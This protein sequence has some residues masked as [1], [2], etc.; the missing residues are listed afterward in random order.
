[1]TDIAHGDLK[2]EN[3]L[4]KGFVNPIAQL[5][6]FDGSSFG[7]TD[8][9]HVWISGTKG[10]TDPELTR[11]NRTV[12]LREA[13]K[14]DLYS[15]GKL[16]AWVVFR[17]ILDIDDY[18]KD[19]G[20]TSVQRYEF[21]DLKSA[22]DNAR[23]VNSDGFGSPFKPS[24]LQIVESMHDFFSTMLIGCRER[25]CVNILQ[26]VKLLERILLSAKAADIANHKYAMNV[27]QSFGT[28]LTDRTQSA[29]EVD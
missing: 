18:M 10:W 29:P 26:G 7:L 15:F 27:W 24:E 2:P 14:A 23:L 19:T 11:G 6:D 3:V 12:E 20:R 9:D 1:M 25:R 4:V 21:F 16:C 8:S 5:I 17:R 22:I 28:L 13:F